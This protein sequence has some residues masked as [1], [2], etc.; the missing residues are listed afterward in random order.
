MNPL[1]VNEA[2]ALA[3]GLPAVAALVRL[4]PGVNSLMLNEV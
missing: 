3:E 2:R 4:L 1:M